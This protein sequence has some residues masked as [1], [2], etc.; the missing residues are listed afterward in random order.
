MEFTQA[1]VKKH[2]TSHLGYDK[3]PGPDGLTAEFY[4][5][6][7][8][9]LT[10]ILTELYNHALQHPR[11]WSHHF[12]ESQI[13]LLHKK[14][15]TTDLKNYRPIALLNT[16]YKILTGAL[17]TRLC[18]IAPQI[19]SSTQTGFVKGRLIT[20]CIHT[21]DLA[22]RSLEIQ[23]ERGL[24]LFLDQEKAYDRVA[25]DWLLHCLIHWNFPDNMAYLIHALNATATTRLQVDGFMSKL[26]QQHSGVRQG[27]PLSPFLYN[28]TLEPL[29]CFLR[30]PE[31]SHINGFQLPNARLTNTHYADDTALFVPEG[32]E[33]QFAHAL[34]LYQQASGAKLNATKGTAIRVGRKRATKDQEPNLPEIFCKIPILQD[35]EQCK[36]LGVPVPQRMGKRIESDWMQRSKSI[37]RIIQHWTP[38]ATTLQGRVAV[39]NS[40]LY[41]QLYYHASS[42]YLST[43]AIHKLFSAPVHQFLWKNRRFHPATTHLMMSKDEGGLNL[44]NLPARFTALRIKALTSIIT[45]QDEAAGT[46]RALLNS[47]I[48][49]TCPPLTALIQ[50]PSASPVKRTRLPQ[51]WKQAILDTREF[52][53]ISA[54]HSSDQ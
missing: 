5:M 2:I 15:P 41:S 22:I 26:I 53:E 20:D 35:G 10:P 1:E 24:I 13:C 29:N 39:A 6:F 9:P 48:P 14:G 45:R 27:C 40:L 37:R 19:L 52:L 33:G 38:R 32:E 16:D 43:S 31:H 18:N 42:R 7:Q 21:V 4:R 36:Y 46:I 17:N 11:S 8:Q 51:F 54:P 28:L 47:L 3:A 30:S 34:N 25:H 49:R 23:E 50:W 12:T 44:S